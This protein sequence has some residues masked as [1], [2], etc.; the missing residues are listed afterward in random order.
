[1]DPISDLA[2]SSSILLPTQ[3]GKVQVDLKTLFLAPRRGIRGEFVLSKVC[4][5]IIFASAFLNSGIF[6][7]RS[8][9]IK[10]TPL[11]VDQVEPWSVTKQSLVMSSNKRFC[12]W[13]SLTHSWLTY[14]KIPIERSARTA[15]TK[16]ELN[17][18]LLLHGSLFLKCMYLPEGLRPPQIF[19]EELLSEIRRNASIK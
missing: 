11:L 3:A 17:H 16:N 2:W 6:W 12:G 1:M 13:K 8:F 4:G 14:E 5:S 19:V 18:H 10:S 7:K 15:D 9:E